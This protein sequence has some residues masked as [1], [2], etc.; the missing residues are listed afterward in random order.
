LYVFQGQAT[1]AIDRAA[2]SLRLLG[3]SRLC[4]CITSMGNSHA[5]DN[6]TTR[7]TWS[8]RCYESGCYVSFNFP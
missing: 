3:Y 5:Y 7:T 4:A 8:C 1:K 2:N 6:E